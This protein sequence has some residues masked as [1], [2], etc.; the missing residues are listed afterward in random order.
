MDLESSLKNLVLEQDDVAWGPNRTFRFPKHGGT[1]R[2]YEKTAAK[3]MDRVRLKATVASVDAASRT[4]RTA[5]GQTVTYDALLNTGPLDRLVAELLGAE[6][7][8]ALV[9]AAGQLA[10]NSVYVAGVGVDGARDDDTCWMYF[11]ESNAPYYRLT[12]FHNYSPYNASKPH[13]A[14]ALMAETSYSAHKPEDLD[15]LMDET[16]DGL[17]ATAML[18]ED[19]RPRVLSRWSAALDYGYPVPTLGRDKALAQLQP[20]LEARG[21]YSRGRFGGWKY[22][23]SNMDHSVMQGVEWAERMVQGKAE[24]TYTVPRE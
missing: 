6:R 5:D 8:D 2:I 19:D 24:T 9:Q 15:S 20:W 7:S 12:N 3:F 10:H 16:V 1:G 14:R 23:V 13:Q 21:V 11:P 18:R 4:V 22:E 17:V